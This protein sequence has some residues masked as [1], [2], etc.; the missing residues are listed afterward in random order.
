MN[1]KILLY[2]LSVLFLTSCGQNNLK[3]KVKKPSYLLRFNHVLTE[4]DPYQE[5]FLSWADKVL[6]RTDGDLQIE[7]YH[8]AQLG[9]EE[10]IIEQM[11]QGANIGQNSDAARLGNFV[12][13]IS[14]MNGPFFIENLDDVQKLMDSPT[15]QKW[16]KQLEDEYDIKILSFAYVQGYRHLLAN[17]K[18]VSPSELRSLAIRT[19]PAPIWVESVRS[20]GVTPVSIPYG[21]MYT[22]IQ[23]KIVDG[24]ELSYVA[25][26]NTKLHEVVK[27]IMETGHIYQMN[28]SIVGKEWFD[29]LPIEY[30][31]ILIEEA[32]IAGF[33]VSK[34]IELMANE[35]KE[36]IRDAGVKIIERDS[37]DIE[38]FK[39][40]SIQAYQAL[41]LEE[42]RD[43]VYKDIGK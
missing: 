34:K 24:A 18:G 16:S 23:T 38:A 4:Q 9:V 22:G 33:E 21:E 1:Q 28:F 36:K 26:Y 42:A 20:L 3:E 25:T 30:Q 29:S 14:V 12:K 11:R 10:D 35:A 39:K 17:K 41:G 15:I 5:A 31:K 7:V 32:D 19:A 37:L 27:Y 13:E 2:C 8:S 40:S 6:E 43:T